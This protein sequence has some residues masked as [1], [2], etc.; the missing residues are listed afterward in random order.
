MPGRRERRLLGADGLVGVKI[1]TEDDGHVDP[2]ERVT[3]DADRAQPQGGLDL[4]RGRC[5]SAAQD[6]PGRVHSRCGI[7]H[8]DHV[9]ALPPEL[10]GSEA[11]RAVLPRPVEHFDDNPRAT[12]RDGIGVTGKP[13]AAEVQHHRGQRDDEET[14]RG[15]DQP[16]ALGWS[17]FQNRTVGSESGIPEAMACAMRAWATDRSTPP[18]S[19]GKRDARLARSSA[20]VF[21]P[22]SR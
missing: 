20:S 14:G 16:A 17:E 10:P 7:A 9:E 15:R 8:I 21:R 22:G 5:L 1:R 12:R 11:R 13:I 4:F 19:L 6:D 2:A 18:E 3:F